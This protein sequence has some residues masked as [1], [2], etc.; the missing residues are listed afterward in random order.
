MTNR[1]TYATI[2][3]PRKEEK[4]MSIVKIKNKTT[5]ITYVYES[6]S[7]WDKE[8]KQPR[9]HRTL[10]GKLDENGEI[11]PT[12]KRGRPRKIDPVLTD[13]DR[14]KIE[15]KQEDIEYYK[16]ELTNAQAE[17]A[18][19]RQ[20]VRKLTREKQEILDA[21]QKLIGDLSQA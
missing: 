12:G 7:Y 4:K 16:Q 20:Q 5:G 1:D 21:L 3:I 8:K 15:K 18:G 10:I 9:N 6:E 17:A 19:L 14:R 2:N 11:V 13:E